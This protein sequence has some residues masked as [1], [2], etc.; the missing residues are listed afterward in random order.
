MDFEFDLLKSASNKLKHGIDFVN[1]QALWED[2]QRMEIQAK[3]AMEEPRWALIAGIDDTIWTAIFTERGRR[4]RIISVRK[5]R[6]EEKELYH[7]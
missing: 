6:E 1:A 3:Q 5:A 2:P 7:G 4:I